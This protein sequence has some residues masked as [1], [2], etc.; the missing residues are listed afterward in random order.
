[1]TKKDRTTDQSFWDD[2]WKARAR[3]RSQFEGHPFYGNGG[4]FLEMVTREVGGLKGRTVIELGG[5]G[6]NRRLLGLAKW[7]GATVSAVD[8]S[9]EALATLRRLFLTADTE[10]T[11]FDGDFFELDF[12]GRQY[13]LVT[14]WGTLEHFADPQA[15]LDLSRRLTQPEGAVLFGM[16][17]MLGIGSYAWRRWSPAGW[18]KHI[19]HTDEVIAAA[20]ERAGLEL[21]RCFYYGRPFLAK[22]RCESRSPVALLLAGAQKTALAAGMVMPSL[23]RLSSSTFASERIFLA[24]PR[25]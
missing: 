24:L 18:S 14:H 25:S 10:V 15:L 17:N 20:C 4:A 6:N 1:M 12:G 8:F 2:R 7:A 9:H 23:N 5:G 19:L 11:V 22:D 21:V 3:E 16:P 13:D